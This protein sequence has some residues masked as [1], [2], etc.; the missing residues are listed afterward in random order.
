MLWN[1]DNNNI[2][3]TVIIQPYILPYQKYISE[4]DF[5]K[6]GSK[7]KYTSMQD[8]YLSKRGTY[9]IWYLV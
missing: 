7:E 9:D 1:K 2:E 4:E 8:L 3:R 6:V 5:V